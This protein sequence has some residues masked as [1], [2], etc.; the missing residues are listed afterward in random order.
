[1]TDGQVR[2]GRGPGPF[3]SPGGGHGE[4]KDPMFHSKTEFLYP[5]YLIGE[6]RD[7]R[8]EEW[9]RLVDQV[10]DLPETHPDT[11]AFMLMMVEVCECL[12]CSSTS[13][14]YLRGCSQCAAQMIRSF[15]G[16]DGEL[17]TLFRAAQGRISQ[18]LPQIGRHAIELDLAA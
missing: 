8:G 16:S 17:L 3:R 10:K 14:K 7:L 11:L 2:I 6:L 15:K 9:R 1:M 18:E 5:T 4:V 12:R 13:Y